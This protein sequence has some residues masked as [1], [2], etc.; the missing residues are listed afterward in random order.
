MA[1]FIMISTFGCV[2]HGLVL[3]GARAYYAMAR[4]RLILQE[5]RCVLKPR[6]RVPAWSLRGA[7]A[8]GCGLLV[9]TAH[10]RTHPPAQYGHSL[11]Q[12]ARLM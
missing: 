6:R 9:L 12:S 2:E 4:D 3:A 7:S 5:S 11:L 8:S 1:V 10:L